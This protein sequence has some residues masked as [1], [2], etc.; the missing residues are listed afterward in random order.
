VEGSEID[1]IQGMRE[2]LARHRPTLICELHETNEAF[3]AAM[4]E[5]GYRAVNLESPEPLGG[6]PMSVHALAEPRDA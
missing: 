3:L 5:A 6:A 1:V 4:D 2:T